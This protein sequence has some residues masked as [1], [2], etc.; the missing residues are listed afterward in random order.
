MEKQTKMKKLVIHLYTKGFLVFYGLILFLILINPANALLSDF[1]ECW[2]FENDNGYYEKYN[3]TSN[4][5]D[6]VAGL[7]GNGMDLELSENDSLVFDLLDSNLGKEHTISC[8]AKMESETAMNLFQEESGG[9]RDGLRYGDGTKWLFQA[10]YPAISADDH[11][12]ID[13]H[14]IG[15]YMM[16]TGKR[17]GDGQ[18]LSIYLNGT[19]KANSTNNAPAWTTEGEPFRTREDAGIYFD[20]I[21]DT[22]VVWANRSLESSEILSLYNSSAGLNCS[23]I[24]YISDNSFIDLLFTNTTDLLFY[25]TVFDDGEEIFGYANW[26]NFSGSPFNNSV[27]ECNMTF[28][29]GVLEDRSNNTNFTI[30]N[31]GCDFDTFTEQFEFHSANLTDPVVED[32]VRFDACHLTS[33]VRDIKVSVQCGSTTNNFTVDKS[34]FPLCSTGTGSII[35]NFTDCINNLT[36][37]ASVG[38]GAIN[39]GQGHRIVNFEVDREYVAHLNNGT[40]FFFNITLQLWQ[41]SHT[42][43]Y[44]EQGSKQVFANCT[45]ITNNTFSISRSENITIVNVP[46]QIFIEQVTTS[47]GTTALF[48]GVEIEFANGTWAWFIAVVDNDIDHINYSWYNSSGGM[49]FSATANGTP[50]TVNTSSALFA[51]FG[52]N[53]FNLT[54][55]ANDTFGNSTTLSIAFNVTDNVDP[56]CNFLSSYV[57]PLTSLLLN[58]TCTDEN[59]Y[60][61]NV[62]CPVNN[63][64]NFTSGLNVVSFNLVDNFIINV[65]ETC[66]FRYCDGHTRNNLLKYWGAFTSES[67]I[68]VTA[69]NVHVANIWTDTPGGIVTYSVVKDRLKYNF[70]MSSSVNDEFT[71]YVNTS[72]N[73]HYLR[74]DKYLGWLVINNEYWLDFNS[75]QLDENDKVKVKILGDGVFEV[76]IKTNDKNIEFESIGELNCIEGSFVVIPAFQYAL[77]VGECPDT[78]ADALVLWLV[79]LFACGLIVAGWIWKFRI[80]GVFGSLLMITISWTIVACHLWAGYITAGIGMYYLL[81]FVLKK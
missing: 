35:V 73:S 3:I 68:E 66:S 33:P 19:W 6:I 30:C 29:A 12:F 59:F 64:S 52:G 13:E 62:T 54:V 69:D 74:S 7:I 11:A 40:D 20:G 31:S 5:E 25:K 27:G 26:T 17:N 70:N 58:I 34:E 38:N 15:S 46:P 49:I 81:W 9:A 48:D 24:A 41:T 60:S 22:C 14:V 76:T 8:W 43:E 1:T 39:I 78:I 21:I 36:M 75:N 18:K 32:T 72:V 2:D 42:H 16:I 44:Y 79:F 51:D 77:K 61:I 37:N 23:Q 47:L 55:F 57:L 4:G 50:E 56:S 65:R 63:Q 53:P 80:T 10:A 28:V 71:F 67:R 45:H